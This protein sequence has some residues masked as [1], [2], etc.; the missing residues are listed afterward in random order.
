MRSLGT[1][2]CFSDVHIGAECW[3]YRGRGEGD[4]LIIVSDNKPTG[5]LFSFVC[6]LEFTTILKMTLS[7]GYILHTWRY[8]AGY[9]ETLGVCKDF[10]KNGG[11]VDGY[12]WLCTQPW[13]KLICL[14]LLP[15]PPII[16]GSM[17]FSTRWILTPSTTLPRTS[18]STKTLPTSSSSQVKT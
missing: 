10:R 7:W 6:C 16:F 3:S 8:A 14:E 11:I 2:F 15:A 17:S 13:R 4:A 9:E 1:Y 12:K 5:L 18:A